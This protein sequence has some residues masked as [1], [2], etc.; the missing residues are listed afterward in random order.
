MADIL[1]GNIKARFD[2]KCLS[3]GNGLVL[4]CVSGYTKLG[5]TG[6]M[7]V[8]GLGVSLIDFAGKAMEWGKM[9]DVKTVYY[10][11]LAYPSLSF[12][13]R[14][15][16]EFDVLRKLKIWSGKKISGLVDL[17]KGVAM[18]S[19]NGASFHET[20]EDSGLIF[21]KFVDLAIG[22]KLGL[23]GHL[24]SGEANETVFLLRDFRGN[25]VFEIDPNGYRLE[26][27]TLIGK[28]MRGDEFLK[29][30][31]DA[32]ISSLKAGV[33]R[34]EETEDGYDVISGN[35]Y[36][37][38][39]KRGGELIYLSFVVSDL[40]IYSVAGGLTMKNSNGRIYLD[41][42]VGNAKLQ[43]FFA[44][45]GEKAWKILKYLIF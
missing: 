31:G 4:W 20:F 3:I 29:W 30:L 1:G 23:P 26:T 21:E 14:V 25:Q 24:L 38:C 19:M 16:I 13:G 28:L 43:R 33:Q 9:K 6:N 27:E 34:Y 37:V 44:S 40:I 36:F 12:K 22:R 8:D 15:E 5:F 10:G 18:V 35:F 32:F 11:G 2:G 39:R 17:E 7:M 42:G 41:V 45:I